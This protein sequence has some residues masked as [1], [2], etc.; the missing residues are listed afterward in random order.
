M[1]EVVGERNRIGDADARESQ[2]A[3]ILQ[4]GDI[5]GRTEPQSMLAASRNSGSKKDAASSGRIGP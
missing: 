3:L 4:I 2:S 5:L 1:R